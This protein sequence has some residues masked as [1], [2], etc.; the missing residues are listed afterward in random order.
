MWYGR[1]W[2]YVLVCTFARDQAFTDGL[3]I[4]SLMPFET[5]GLQTPLGRR[6][7]Y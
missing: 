4:H 7:G 2:P 3:C 1:V 6:S 5:G